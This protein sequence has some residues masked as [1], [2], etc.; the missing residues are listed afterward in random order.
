MK[1]LNRHLAEKSKGKR[2]KNY[3]DLEREL[4]SLAVQM[5][6]YREEVGIS[7][8]ELAT[9]AKITQQ[10]LSKIENGINCNIATILKVCAALDLKIDFHKNR[11]KI[12][13]A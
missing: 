12:V 7:Q 6:Q 2:F 11:R 1:T 4:L 9:R 8:K 5:M 13:A 10:Q 3:F